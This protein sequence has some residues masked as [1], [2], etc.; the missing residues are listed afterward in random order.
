MKIE[1]RLENALNT[2]QPLTDADA[3]FYIHEVTE[4]TKMSKGMLYNNAHNFALGKYQVSP[5]SVY[6]ADVIN[7]VN[8]LEPGSFNNRWLDFWDKYSNKS[9]NPS[10]GK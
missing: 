9:Y 4:A 1:K 2:G 8:A 6:H 10:P 3:S 5:F 7:Q